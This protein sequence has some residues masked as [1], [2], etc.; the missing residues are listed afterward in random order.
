MFR[1]EVFEAQ[2]LT[3]VNNFY[4]T[5]WFIYDKY[6]IVY[7]NA[8]LFCV[9]AIRDGRCHKEAFWHYRMKF[10]KNIYTKFFQSTF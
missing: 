5:Y 7:K 1:M 6:D 2:N 9:N 10:H 4:T 3:C 8:K